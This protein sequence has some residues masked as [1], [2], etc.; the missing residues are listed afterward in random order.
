[1]SVHKLKIYAEKTSGYPCMFME[2]TGSQV[3]QKTAKN[4]ESTM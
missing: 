3:V 2:M 4:F 1:M